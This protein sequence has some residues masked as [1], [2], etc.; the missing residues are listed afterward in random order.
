MIVGMRILTFLLL[1]VL[2]AGCAVPAVEAPPA[3]TP[4]TLAFTPIENLLAPGISPGPTTTLGYLL[5]D[6]SGGRLS[7]A[8]SFA[9]GEPRS[10][11][12]ASEQIWC[13][14]QAQQVLNGNA[15]GSGALRYAIVLASGF[16]EGPGSY[17]PSGA[18]RYQLREPELTVLAPEETTI[19]ALLEQNS[20][21]YRLVRVNGSL[22]AQAES[23]LLVDQLGSGGIPATN[24]HA[25]KLRSAVRDQALID[26]LQGVPGSQLRYGLV[27]VEGYW[28]A[29]TLTP[30]AMLRVEQ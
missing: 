9:S 25:I 17:G 24:A 6:A 23:V 19:A 3:P 8:L 1:L 14:A 28:Y 21:D 30:L 10:L 29:G 15:L 7:G 22:L 12:P 2:L 20:S 18:Y 4:Q 16:F 5:L 27:Q 13:G 26:R 11:T